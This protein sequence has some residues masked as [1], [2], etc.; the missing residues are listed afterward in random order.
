MLENPRRIAENS[1]FIGNSG[2]LLDKVHQ[3]Y[4]GVYGSGNQL[5]GFTDIAG[6]MFPVMK[7][8]GFGGNVRL[9]VLL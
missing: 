7:F 3:R 5:I 9:K 2:L 4:F 8:N 1:G 6:V